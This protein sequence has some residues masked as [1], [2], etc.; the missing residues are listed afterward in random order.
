MI[1]L[2]TSM[3][4]DE[5]R[6]VLEEISAAYCGALAAAHDSVVDV[7]GIR[8]WERREEFGAIA[9]QGRHAAERLNTDEL[10]AVERALRTAHKR[11]VADVRDLVSNLTAEKESTLAALRE[12]LASLTAPDSG[13]TGRAGL[14]VARMRRLADLDDLARIKSGIRESADRLETCITAIQR[15][16][17]TVIL[18]LR[19]EIR[20][21]QRSLE[22]VKAG[23]RGVLS[24]SQFEACL[25]RTIASK[26]SFSVIQVSIRN[27]AHI[28]RLKG[29]GTAEHAVRA[30]AAALQELLPPGSV[31]GMW[32]ETELCAIVMV[33]YH[34]AIQKTRE[35]GILLERSD[36]KTGSAPLKAQLLTV[37]FNGEEGQDKLAKR[38]QKLMAG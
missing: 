9:A 26:V 25:Q 4:L 30:F 8:A 1:S 23:G 22:Q 29:P 17:D 20:T 14:E 24:R 37:P 15:E 38:V 34:D 11:Q 21:L 7:K 3:R 12:A 13:E 18:M 32:D 10:P 27:R 31:T 35:I 33:S 16:K 6:C 19:D 28:E 5:V 2:N 36:T